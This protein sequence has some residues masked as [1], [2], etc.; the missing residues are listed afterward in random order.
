MCLLFLVRAAIPE[1]WAAE[2]VTIVPQLQV[3]VPEEG[4]PVIS[5]STLTQE[6][7]DSLVLQL[8]HL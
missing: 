6:A 8:A 4:E 7:A 3:M 1:A 2:A 5:S